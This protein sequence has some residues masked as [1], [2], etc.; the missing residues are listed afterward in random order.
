MID[1]TIINYFFGKIILLIF[2]IIGIYAVIKLYNKYS[3][4]LDFKMDS[5][6]KRKVFE[7]MLLIK[8]AKDRHIDLS[9]ELEKYEKRD[10]TRK[11]VV[12]E[13]IKEELEKIKEGDG[14]GKVI[15]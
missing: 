12:T 6:L 5:E 9:K 13:I 3:K 14:W 1:T 11:S 10:A 4:L 7:D 15:E 2:S 8:A